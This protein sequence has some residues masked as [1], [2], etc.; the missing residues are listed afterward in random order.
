MVLAS[1]VFS[2]L[3]AMRHVGSCC[4]GGVSQASGQLASGQLASGPAVQVRRVDASGVC[5]HSGCDHGNPFRRL[6]G[7]E[8]N[9]NESIAGDL[10]TSY[11]SAP[12]HD[13]D[14]CAICRWFVVLSS[15]VHFDAPGVVEFG[16]LVA[17]PVVVVTG[18]PG[19]MM[20]LPTVSRRG[21]PAVA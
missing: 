16:E 9:A 10:D 14:S 19:R 13:R 15:G 2:D 1:L 18:L 8:P 17:E 5:G 12:A 11:P 3:A 4:G 6:G 20:F 7:S 21:P